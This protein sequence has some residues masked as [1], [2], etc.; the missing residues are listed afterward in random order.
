MSDAEIAVSDIYLQENVTFRENKKYLIKA[1]S[2]RGKTSLL[3]F[4]YGSNPNFE[5]KITYNSDD[6]IDIFQLRKNKISY[7]FQDLKLFPK[8]TLLQN[9]RIKNNLTNHKTSQE[10]AQLIEAVNLQD[11]TNKPL[12]NFSLGQQQ[13]V[14][15]IRA[16]CQPF[17]ILLLDEPFSHL[18]KQNIEIITDLI[19]KEV[20]K[21]NASIIMT[22]LGSKYAFDFDETLNL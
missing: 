3:N 14:A 2:G 12:E 11:K 18:D 1:N 16:L 9:V 20:Q 10:I 7:V 5:G 17:E 13:R 6:D 8:L 21:Q 4:I 15:I 22:S 19:Y